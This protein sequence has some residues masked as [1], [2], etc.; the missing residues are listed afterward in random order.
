MKILIVAS[1]NFGR[2]SPFV[3]EQVKALEKK[4][5]E[6]EWFPIQGKGVKGYLSNRKRL[7]KKI[8]ISNPDLIHAHYGLSG[9]LANTQRRVP[10]ITTYHGSD[11]HSKGFLLFLSKICMCLSSYNIFVSRELYDISNYK[12]DN[13]SIIPCGVNLDLFY[14][15]EKKRARESLN[16]DFN[17]IYFLFSGSFDNSIKNY[18]LASEAVSLFGDCELIELNGFSREKVNLLMNACDCLLL[19]SYREGSPMVIKEA[20]ACGCPIISVDVGD[21]AMQLKDV[22]GCYIARR[23]AVDIAEK[24]ALVIKENKK[25]NGRDIIMQ[26]GL[27]NETITGC[28]YDIYRSFL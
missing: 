10:V 28:I 13:Y 20:L 1:Y 16:W 9:L 18:P 11:I 14:P 19:T 15:V 12:K 3:V 22:T 7:L 24:L 2:F 17:S 23:D 4:G 26:N 21:V 27:D 25:T 5:I 6:V 8:K